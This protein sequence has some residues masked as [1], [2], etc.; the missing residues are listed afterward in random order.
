MEV[1]GYRQN[2]FSGSLF[3]LV[4]LLHMIH[5]IMKVQVSLVCR[6]DSFVDV[7]KFRYPKSP[8]KFIKEFPTDKKFHLVTG[9]LRTVS[10][11]VSPSQI[12]SLIY[13]RHGDSN[14]DIKEFSK[15]EPRNFR[16]LVEFKRKR[17]DLYNPLLGEKW[18][19][20]LDLEFYHGIFPE[21]YNPD[22]SL[23]GGPVNKSYFYILA[24]PHFSESGYDPKSLKLEPYTNNPERFEV[25]AFSKDPALQ[26]NSLY[27]DRP[28]DYC[29]RLANEFLFHKKPVEVI[30][31]TGGMEYYRD[32]IR[33]NKFVK[34]KIDMDRL[35]MLLSSS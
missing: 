26:F 16:V 11:L 4:E 8:I 22:V 25:N 31:W 34:M 13:L 19:N 32:A 24:D 33:K 15:S 6:N 17:I 35:G 3:Y 21:Y 5:K 12:G 1:I 30:N 28:F 27:Y 7:I 23:I 20:D 14:R 2:S 29:P 10:S 18:Y 9:S